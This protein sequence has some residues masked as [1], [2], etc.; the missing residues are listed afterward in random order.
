MLVVE[1]KYVPTNAPDPL[2]MCG[3]ITYSSV[4]YNNRVALWD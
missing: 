4:H 2:Q 1:V 3:Y